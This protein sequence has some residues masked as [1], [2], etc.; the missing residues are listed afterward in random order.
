M[1]HLPAAFKALLKSYLQ[2]FIYNV[3][4]LHIQVYK[5]KLVCKPVLQ[6]I[7]CT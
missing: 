3:F 6:I 7:A 2:R 4:I 5:S 1:P